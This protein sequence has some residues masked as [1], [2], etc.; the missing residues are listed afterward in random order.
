M[1]LLHRTSHEQYHLS[2]KCNDWDSGKQNIMIPSGMSD[3]QLDAY[4]KNNSGEVKVYKL[5]E[6]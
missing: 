1:N 5:E 4:V 6:E 2:K 3:K